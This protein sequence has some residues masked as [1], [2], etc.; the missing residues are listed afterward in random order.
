MS[1]GLRP[2]GLRPTTHPVFMAP[3]SVISVGVATGSVVARGALWTC[4]WSCGPWWIALL[5]LGNGLLDPKLATIYRCAGLQNERLFIAK[6][7]GAPR[8]AVFFACLSSARPKPMPIPRHLL[9]RARVIERNRALIFRV[10]S[11]R[12]F[13]R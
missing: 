11:I 8:K 5:S 13:D 7:R 10:P 4:A 1:P 9:R 3:Q 12:T 2:Y 6:G